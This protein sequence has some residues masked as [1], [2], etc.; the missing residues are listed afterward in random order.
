MKLVYS[1]ERDGRLE[2]RELPFVIG[3]IGA[4]SGSPL[5]P[6]A[7]LAD[8]EFVEVDAA[9]FDDFRAAIRPRAVFKAENTLSADDSQLGVELRCDN[10]FEPEDIARQVTPVRM[11]LDLKQRLID[12]LAQLAFNPKLEAAVHRCLTDEAFGAMVREDDAAIRQLMADCGW[13]DKPW[14]GWAGHGTGEA[15]RTLARD[16]GDWELPHSLDAGAMLRAAIAQID[17]LAARQTAAVLQHPEFQELESAWRGLEYL[18][19]RCADSPSVKIKV[20]NVTK[21]EMLRDLRRAPEFDLSALFRLVYEREFGALG[22]QPFSLLIGVYEFSSQPEDVELLERISQVA[23]AAHS[24]FVAA[25]GPG[26]FQV[27]SFADLDSA[28][29]LAP[30]FQSTSYAKWRYFR[31]YEDSY[32][33]A[34]VMPRMLLRT[35]FAAADHLWGNAAFALAANV[36]AAFHA[37]TVNNDGFAA[38]GGPE[39]GGLVTELPAGAGPVTDLFISDARRAEL[40]GLGFTPLCAARHAA[41][42]VFFDLVSCHA[43]ATEGPE[44]ARQTLGA[45]LEN[46]LITARFSHYLKSIIRDKSGSIAFAADWESFLNA[47]LLR[48]VG[49]GA[50]PL[51]SGSLKVESSGRG[52]YA[53]AAITPRFSNRSVQVT[54][55]LYAALPVHGQPFDAL[56]RITGNIPYLGTRERS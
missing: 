18:V 43:P 6:L 17:G 47:W 5:E 14:T 44:Q 33:V 9:S 56:T 16:L 2:D 36:A 4:F 24:I 42:A 11:L 28:R 3:V 49:A 37:E 1:V 41:E 10:G 27:E 13:V 53:V 20:L 34:L 45:R 38:A 22:G 48:Y 7:R 51:S 32:Y 25:A 21:R 39:K 23:S 50:Q 19:K 29:S 54:L 52:F 46:L 35:A 26:M 15:L 40:A 31:D 8:R 12:L 30:V 55:R